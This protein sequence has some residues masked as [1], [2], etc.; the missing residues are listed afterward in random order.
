MA[1]TETLSTYDKV[2]AYRLLQDLSLRISVWQGGNTV[3]KTM[4]RKAL[5]T[6]I[7]TPLAILIRNEAQ[8]LVSEHETKVSEI[9]Y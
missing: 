6:D 7:Q 3:S 4:L 8:I 9:L 1:Q 5:N 2:K